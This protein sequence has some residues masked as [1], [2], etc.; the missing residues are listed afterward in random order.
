MQFTKEDEQELD[1]AL[2]KIFPNK[3]FPLLVRIIRDAILGAPLFEERVKMMAATE[4]PL[5]AEFK[6]L[7]AEVDYL[8][9]KVDEPPAAKP[10]EDKG[11]AAKTESREE[12]LR[13]LA[14]GISA[15]PD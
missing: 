4:H 7:E 14:G 13:R 10:V 2:G 8:R 12:K 3:T 9:D 11:K 15:P 5:N 6:R 1:E